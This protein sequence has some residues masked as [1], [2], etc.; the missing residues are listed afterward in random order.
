LKD[1]P[2]NNKSY[3]AQYWI[4][5]YFI[6]LSRQKE[7]KAKEKVLVLNEA[8]NQQKE[9]ISLMNNSLTSQAEKLAE[10]NHTKDKLFAILGHDLR[11]PI[12]SLEGALSLM[13][14]GGFT[15]DELQTLIPNLHKNVKNMQNTLDNLLQWAI[16][17][18]QGMNVN[19]TYILLDDIIDEQIKLFAG[20]AKAKQIT[21][22]TEI[23]SP[24]NAWAD[25]NHIRLILRNLIN[26]ALK[27]TPQGGSIKVQGHFQK[28]QIVVDVID[29]GI[30]MNEEQLAKLFKANQHFSTSGTSGE[31]G[32]GLGL[33][34]CQEVVTKNGG[35]I[36]VSSKQG[37]GS[38]FSFSLP[39]K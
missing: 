20:V 4:L 1:L 15:P 31:K 35:A 11:S 18:M 3:A 28:A 23:S 37:Q 39:A 34:L 22:T 24:L 32:T 13:N 19:P 30:G 7:K 2:R 9:E 5:T 27:F 38:T 36:W 6:Y 17:Q 26:N 16:S 21:I 8:I 12:S 10:S 14:T 29:T 25:A 33:L